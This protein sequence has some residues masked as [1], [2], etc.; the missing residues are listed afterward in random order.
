MWL[1]PNFYD[2]Y[3][4]KLINK[5]Q[6]QLNLFNNV[7]LFSFN[8]YPF[9]ILITSKINTIIPSDIETLSEDETIS[10]SWWIGFLT[11]KIKKFGVIL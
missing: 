1:C 7:L 8:I 3:V 5:D 4:N 9:K 11:L 2:I 10:D 6:K